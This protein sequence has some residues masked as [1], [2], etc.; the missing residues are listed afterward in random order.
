MFVDA[1][2]VPWSLSG[3]FAGLGFLHSASVLAVLISRCCAPSVFGVLFSMCG[4]VKTRFCMR[5]WAGQ[6]LN[7]RRPASAASPS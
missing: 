2:T 4:G 1:S 3:G 6:G 5:Q 7:R